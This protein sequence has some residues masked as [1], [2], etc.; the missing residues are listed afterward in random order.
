MTA[1]EIKL[2][3]DSWK[4]AAPVADT[5]V[6]LFYLRLFQLAPELRGRFHTSMSDQGDQLVAAIDD[7]T[8]CLAH[9][10]DT[11]LAPAP[12][13][14]VYADVVAKAWTWTLRQEL[15]R[16]APMAT[17][18]AWRTVLSSPTSAALYSIAV[19]E[20]ELAVA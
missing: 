13:G 4:Q 3:C 2:V 17:R 8:D 5:V 14:G 18:K 7:L 20:L 16:K 15:G 10:E 11:L 6:R 1:R 9:G 19:G 12:A